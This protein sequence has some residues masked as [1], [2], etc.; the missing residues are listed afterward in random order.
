MW[1]CHKYVIIKEHWVIESNQGPHY[2]C[3]KVNNSLRDTYELSFSSV[4]F[5]MLFSI[6]M[7]EIL[8]KKLDC[9]FWIHGKIQHL[10]LKISGR[11]H[12]DGT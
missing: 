2:M 10:E 12:I 5:E 1:M 6:P 3:C 7:N 4:K 11:K 8:S 9:M